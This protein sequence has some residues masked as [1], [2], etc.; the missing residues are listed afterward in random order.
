M[1]ED[2]MEI[3]FAYLKS[4]LYRIKMFLEEDLMQ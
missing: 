1:I 2:T 3:A 4:K